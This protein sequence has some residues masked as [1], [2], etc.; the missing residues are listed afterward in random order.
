MAHQ[1]Q[2]RILYSTQS[3]RAKACARRTARILGVN[4][5]S[6]SFDDD[7]VGSDTCQEYVRRRLR[8]V[9][10]TTTMLLI[11]FVSTTGDGEHT[12]CFWSGDF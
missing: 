12:V 10:P 9:F 11:L 5:V 8:P 3:G 2:Y 4:G 1:N 6:K 7:I